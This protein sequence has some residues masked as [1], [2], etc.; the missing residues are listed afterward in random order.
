MVGTLLVGAFALGMLGLG[1]AAALAPTFASRFYG[2]PSAHPDARAW[3]RAAGLRDVGLAAAILAF[4]PL[5]DARAAAIVTL[6][7]VGIAVA[8]VANVLGT[9]GPRPLWPLGTHLSGIVLGVAGAAALLS[10]H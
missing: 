3:I 5:G 8:D 6:A 10:G 2:V 4:A 7:T 9:R 1:A